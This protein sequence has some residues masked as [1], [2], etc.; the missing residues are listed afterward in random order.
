MDEVGE[1]YA[2]QLKHQIL[3]AEVS[4]ADGVVTVALSGSEQPLRAG[5]DNIYA[6][7][8]S[9]PRQLEEIL[10]GYVHSLREMVNN[11]DFKVTAAQLPSLLPVV[12]SID[13]VDPEGAG[14][15]AIHRPLSDGLI[16]ALV[17]DLPNS[18]FYLTPIQQKGLGLAEA[19]LFERALA[20]L[21]AMLPPGPVEFPQSEGIYQLTLDGSYDASLLL[22]PRVREAL[23]AQCIEPVV[24][25]PARD[26]V[27]A[28]S[29]H[30]HKLVGALARMAANNFEAADHAITPRLYRWLPA[31]LE[32]LQV[33]VSARLEA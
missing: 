19:A 1:R 12:R 16:T 18:M 28:V 25:L 22:L 9:H 30:N 15:Q 3:G 2:D 17:V 26:L 4:Y 32:P 20:N 11:L 8:R 21:D 31:G 13:V 23:A 5:V 29:G 14:P 6:L 33:A 10:A 27:V 7:Y 24:A